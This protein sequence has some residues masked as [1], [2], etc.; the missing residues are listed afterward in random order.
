MSQKDKTIYSNTLKIR[1]MKK[2]LLLFTMI[3][4][5]SIVNTK[6][7]QSIFV[8]LT[9]GTIDQTE[10][11]E[12]QK[13][14]FS[15]TDMILHKTDATTMSWA[16]TD[17]QKYYYDDSTVEINTVSA[18]P[19]D[20]LVYP[21]PTKENLNIN[22]QLNKNGSVEI[23]IIS[24]DGRVIEKLL[25]ENKAKGDYTLNWNSQ[26]ESGTYFVKIQNEENITTKKI[27]ILK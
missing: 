17:V 15:A 9:N 8:E 4:F 27:I 23:S 16:I 1:K 22:Y 21:N 20:I 6:A 11:S 14:T 2:I 26:L 18:E 19:I 7:Q 25:S 5:V 13:I 3:L 12:V 24:M 10:L